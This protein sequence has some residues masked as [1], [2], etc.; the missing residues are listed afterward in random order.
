MMSVFCLQELLYSGIEPF[1][2][3]NEVITAD[4]FGGAANGRAPADLGLPVAILN[5]AGAAFDN[6]ILS[7]NRP[8][9]A[10]LVRRL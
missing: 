4:D 8:G 1:A 10:V 7:K 3:P 6:E 5:A 9:I 2:S